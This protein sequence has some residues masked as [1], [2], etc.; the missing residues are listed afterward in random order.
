MKKEFSKIL[1]PHDG[2]EI[3]DK[4]LQEAVKFAELFQ[5]ELLLLYVVDDRF[6]PPS[7]LL[8]FIK[9]RSLRQ[10]KE[11]LIHV[12][13]TGAENMLKDRVE[14][15]KQKKI[16]AK[17]EI[18][19]GSP[20]TDI[21]RVAKHEDVDMIIIGSTSK[22]GSKSITLLGSVSRSV[23]EIAHCPVMLVH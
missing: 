23:S 17:I 16:P 15:I 12:L 3:A 2:S 11:E 21:V 1:V 7:A 13:R 10:A 5:S 4:A 20:A 9:G 8:S 6:S 19:V 14:D 22:K 18:S